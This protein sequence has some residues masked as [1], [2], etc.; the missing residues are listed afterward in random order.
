M[1]EYKT[2][3]Q[4]GA[5][6]LLKLGLTTNEVQ[7]VPAPLVPQDRTYTSAVALRNWLREHNLKPARLHLMSEGPHARRSWLLF[8]KA[9]GRDVVVGITSVPAA[10]YDPKRWW[11][12]SLGVRGVISE[13]LAYGYARFLFWP[14]KD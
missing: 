5:A 11:R 12:T 1:S 6:V 14:G 10:G 7:A 13:A 3:A 9:F 4:R 2:Y 8:E